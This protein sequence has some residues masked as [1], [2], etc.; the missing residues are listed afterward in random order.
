MSHGETVAE[1]EGG[2]KVPLGGV[3]VSSPSLGT[4]CGSCLGC[5]LE[6]CEKSCADLASYPDQHIPQPDA[7]SFLG[8]G[9]NLGKDRHCIG[10]MSL[11][12]KAIVRV[13]VG[14][15]DSDTFSLLHLL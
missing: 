5:C 15:G 3:V 13:R 10:C 9:T 2:V 12:G 8:R 6:T 14:C 4:G 11:M 7:Y 1:E